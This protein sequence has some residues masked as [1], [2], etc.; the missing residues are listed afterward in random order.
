MNVS[1][2]HE[3]GVVVSMYPKFNVYPE[4]ILSDRESGDYIL[5]PE[6]ANQITD[7][8][9]CH[10]AGDRQHPHSREDGAVLTG[11]SHLPTYLSSH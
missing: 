3:E 4:L 2:S 1:Y 7:G 5:E 9:D 6:T 10:G 8:N 11:T